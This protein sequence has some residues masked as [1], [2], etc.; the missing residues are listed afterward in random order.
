MNI[1]YIG[2]SRYVGAKL[3]NAIAPE[4]SV[5]AVFPDK[6][7][8]ETDCSI[9]DSSAD[10]GSAVRD[11]NIDTVICIEEASAA[12]SAVERIFSGVAENPDCRLIYIK[13][14]P[15]FRRRETK[16]DAADWMC[17]ELAGRYGVK[18]VYLSVSCLYSEEKIPSYLQE[19]LESI[20]RR[21]EFCPDGAAEEIC[22]SLHADDFCAAVS[23]I[24]CSDQTEDFWRVQLQSA[25]PFR[26]SELVGSLTERYT[27]VSTLPYETRLTE[28]NYQ[29]YQSDGWS[30]EHSFIKDLSA[31]LDSEETRR[32]ELQ[33]VKRKKGISTAFTIGVFAVLFALVEMYTQFVTVSSDLQFVDLRLLFVVASSLFFGKRYGIA[34]AAMCSVSSVAQSLIAGYRWYVLFY[35][36]DN[37]IPIAVYFVIAVLLGIYQETREKRSRRDAE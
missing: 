31:I 5:T 29:P 30:C 32:R 17:G 16:T 25:Y 3:V 33:T 9:I 37:W 21:R 34:A 1:L 19:R 26:L 12:V 13:E 20:I 4:H 22:D 7:V 6:P 14:Q 28:R 10:I 23:D 15:F 36:V 8:Y 27:S 11:R 2:E 24:L 35:H 18:T